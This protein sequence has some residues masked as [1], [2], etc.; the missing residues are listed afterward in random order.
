MS[1][2]KNPRISVIVPAYN[3]EKYIDACLSSLQKQ[4]I[5]VPYEVI[6]VDNNSTDKTATIAKKYQ[7]V[8]IKNEKRM[9][10]SF[11]RNTGAKTAKGTMLVFLDA[12]CIAPPN[13]LLYIYQ[14]FNRNPNRSVVAGSYFYTDAPSFIKKMLKQGRFYLFYFRLIRLLFGV[15]ILLSGNF[16]SKKRTFISVGGFTTKFNDSHHSEDTEFA[17]RSYEA[18]FKIYFLEK[19]VVSTSFR[20]TKQFNL[21][22]QM[23]RL[24]SHIN[25]LATY[26]FRH[27][28]QS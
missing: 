7:T 15:Q 12:D 17:T 2:H 23:T 19:L 20:R 28:S 24:S 26:A 6:V 9:G 21:I 5:N 18:G 14:W 22:H 13:H 27:V 25:Y 4:T 3:E 1:Q 8:T 10:P 11:A 16:S